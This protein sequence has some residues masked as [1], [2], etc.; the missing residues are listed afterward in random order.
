MNNQPEQID[1]DFED[2]M[3]QAYSLPNGRAKIALL[4]E[5]IRLADSLGDIGQGYSAREELVETATFSGHPMKALVAFSWL[6][7]Q[8]DQQPEEYN[9]FTLLWSYKWI[10]DSIACFPEVSRAQIED[11]LNDMRKRYEQYGYNDRAY[12]Y[13]RFAI[14]KE[15]GELDNAREFLEKTKVMDRDEMSDCEACEQHQ[16]VEFEVMQGDDEKVIQ[17]AKPILKGRLTCGEVPHL[18][19]SKVLMPLYRQGKL[20][21]ATK[22]QK[23]GYRLIKGNRDFLLHAGEHIYYLLNID[24]MQ[25]L[26]VFEQWIGASL[27]HENP[28]DKMMFNAYA[29]VLFKRLAEEGSDIPVK[30][31]ATYPY[32]EDATD[33]KKLAERLEQLALETAGRLDQRNGNDY[34]T[35]LIGQL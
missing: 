15:Y 23:Q 28:R 31:P 21:E 25:A 2:L 14:F 10:L 22:Y 32:A 13:Y 9:D 7:G 17:T 30:L 33:I 11:L 20:E 1:Q 18:T 27:D 6:L 12:H 26:E 5:A 19:L 24:V 3:D 16:F 34:Y 29:S 4:E 35:T 8:F